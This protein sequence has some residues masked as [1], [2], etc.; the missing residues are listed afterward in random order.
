[1]CCPSSCASC[2]PFLSKGKS[3][4][5]R[6]MCAWLPAVWPCLASSTSGRSAVTIR[7]SV[8]QR[9]CHFR[10]IFIV[11]L[12]YRGHAQVMR[13]TVQLHPN[14]LFHVHARLGFLGFGGDFGNDNLSFIVQIGNLL[15]G[16]GFHLLGVD[17]LLL[18]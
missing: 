12:L 6:K 10:H 14:F 18:L 1:M 9:R 2:R 4:R 17:D 16:L 3:M 15:F 11:L 8:H 13:R 7:S 5:E